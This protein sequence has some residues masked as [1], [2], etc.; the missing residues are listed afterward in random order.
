MDRALRR[1]HDSKLLL[2]LG[3]LRSPLTGLGVEMKQLHSYPSYPLASH[4][5]DIFD[6]PGPEFGTHNVGWLPKIY[7][8]AKTEYLD[9][10][11]RLRTGVWQHFYETTRPA[12]CNCLSHLLCCHDD[13]LQYGLGSSVT[14]VLGRLVSTLQRDVGKTSLWN[15]LTPDDEFVTMAR[16]S[17]ILG[18]S[19]FDVRH[20]PSSCFKDRCQSILQAETEDSSL[21]LTGELLHSNHSRL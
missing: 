6:D 12:F 2:A 5:L 14:E 9:L 15:V 8:V 21:L 7:D 16:A 20:L 10:R 4:Y 17:A 1:L 13:S 11:R 19:G 18:Q 3:S